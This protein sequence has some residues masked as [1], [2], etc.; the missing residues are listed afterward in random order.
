MRPR[1]DMECS[2]IGKRRRRRRRRNI[3]ELKTPILAQILTHKTVT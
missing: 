3:Y 2:A 1:P